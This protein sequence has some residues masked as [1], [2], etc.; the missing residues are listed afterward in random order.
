M[1]LGATYAVQPLF[2]SSLILSK[3]AIR[4]LFEFF[5]FVLCLPHVIIGGNLSGT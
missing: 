1:G 2:T 5:Y 4:S 3:L